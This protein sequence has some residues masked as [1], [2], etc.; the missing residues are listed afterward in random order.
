MEHKYFRLKDLV[1]FINGSNGW[2]C[3]RILS[4]NE[5]LFGVARGSSHN[6]QAWEGGYLDH[7]TECMNIAVVLYETFGMIRSARVD[8][9]D[10]LL[11][12]FLHDIE[13]P[14]KYTLMDGKL[15]IRPELE[16]KA[17]QRKFRDQ[18][19]KEYGLGLTPRV[20][21][22]LEYVEGEIHN[23]S[24]KERM[25]NELAAFCHM[26]DIASARLW[27]DYPK[28]NDEYEWSGKRGQIR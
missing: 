21:N 1:G 11:V 5:E 25:M 24:T 19:F 9:S 7:V 26:C 23:H 12:L 8:I 28:V 2:A 27:H 13:K 17:A 6:H 4:D 14:W 15:E 20:Q 16:S 22:A 3:R 18:K 10:A